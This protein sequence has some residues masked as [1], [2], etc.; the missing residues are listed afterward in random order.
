M[1]QPALLAYKEV[2]DLMVQLVYKE[3]PELAPQ[4]QLV[5]K[6]V[7]ELVQLVQLAYKEVPDL[8]VQLVLQ[9]QQVLLE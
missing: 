8:M 9:E 5:Y 4:A 3:V 2:L 6:E 1:G 7:P